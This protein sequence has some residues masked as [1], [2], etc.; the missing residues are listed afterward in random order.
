M[1]GRRLVEP[2][3]ILA[4]AGATEL[5]VFSDGQGP[6]RLLL[7]LAFAL[8]VPGWAALRLVRLETDVLTWL[9]FAVAIST[10]IDI[11]LVLPLLYLGIWSIHLGVSLLLGIIVAL[12][13]IDLP[14][15]RARLRAL[16]GG[17]ILALNRWRMP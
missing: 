7:G 14:V 17:T 9:A 6:A 4:I 13:A 8:V 1:N 11:T 10:A 16:A 3:A 12:V 15:T 2:I 5:L